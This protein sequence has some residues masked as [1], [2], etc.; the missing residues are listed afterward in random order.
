MAITAFKLPSAPKNEETNEKSKFTPIDTENLPTKDM[1][2]TFKQLV[3]I[4]K[5]RKACEDKLE[6]MLTPYFDPPD[7][8]VTVF[9]F[10]YNSI[11]F[12]YVPPR[13]AKGKLVLQ[14]IKGKK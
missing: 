6:E 3:E 12:N 10:R 4:N 7:G 8:L 9:G 11:A 13:Q 2:E 5:A 1:T 14:P